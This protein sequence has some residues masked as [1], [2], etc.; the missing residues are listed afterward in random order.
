[1]NLTPRDLD[2]TFSLARRVRL[3]T[4]SDVVRVWWPESNSFQTAWHRL[5]EMAR[6]GW[7]QLRT[8]NVRELPVTEPL[9]SWAPGRPEPNLQRVSNAARSRWSGI[10]ARCRPSS[11]STQ[12]WRNRVETHATRTKVHF[13]FM[14][15]DATTPP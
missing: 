3:M 8:V 6:G 4:L 5:R 10:P 15:S 7:V 1:M 12:P 13:N 2:I 11:V 9:C 14:A